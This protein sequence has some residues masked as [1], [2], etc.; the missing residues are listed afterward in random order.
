[1]KFG[2]RRNVPPWPINP[3]ITACVQVSVRPIPS[4]IKPGSG[5]AAQPTTRLSSVE[6]TLRQGKEERRA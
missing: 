5:E 3:S 1:M 6:M 2:A 4:N